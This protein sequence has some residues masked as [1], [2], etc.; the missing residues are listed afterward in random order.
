M[1][2]CCFQF[3]S[4]QS[5]FEQWKSTSDVAEPLLYSKEVLARCERIERQVDSLLSYAL[6]RNVLGL[7]AL[8][9][10]LSF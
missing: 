4:L 1:I 10:V 2:I 6:F 8:V 7:V 9:C 3:D 5:A